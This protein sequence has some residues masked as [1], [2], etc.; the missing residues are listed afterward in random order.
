MTPK[1]TQTQRILKMLREGWWLTPA[2]ALDWV[3]TFRLAARIY[4][5]EHNRLLA[6]GESIVHGS[7]TAPDGARVAAYHLERHA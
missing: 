5:I 2:I 7:Y 3:G 1:A 4:D 6:A